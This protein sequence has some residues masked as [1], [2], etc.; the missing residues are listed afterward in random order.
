MPSRPITLIAPATLSAVLLARWGLF[1][2]RRGCGVAAG[3][4]AELTR[5]NGQM[6]GDTVD[7]TFLAWRWL[8]EQDLA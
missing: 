4:I 3:H 5:P 2:Q 6:V 7:V 1:W 8:A